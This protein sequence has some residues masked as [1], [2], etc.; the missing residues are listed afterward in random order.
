M[1]LLCYEYQHYKT[2][3]AEIVLDRPEALNAVDEKMSCRL[4]FVL[5]SWLNNPNI[6]E[7]I[8][9]S[10]GK[11]FCAGADLKTLMA[12]KEVKSGSGEDYFLRQY[13][14]ISMLRKSK[15]PIWVFAS[16]ATVGFGAGLFMAAS[17]RV[18][19]PSFYLAMPE[20][21]IGFFPDVGAIKFL[22]GFK[23]ASSVFFSGATLRIQDLIAAG[24]LNAVVPFEQFDSWLEARP[25]D[26][27]IDYTEPKVF[28]RSSSNLSIAYTKKMMLLTDLSYGEF[29]L[30]EYALAR[31]LVQTADFSQGIDAF[32]KKVLPKWQSKIEL[33][34]LNEMQEN[35]PDSLKNRFI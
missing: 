33:K 17:H 9:R 10:S 1:S 28:N 21:S 26:F 2:K 20:C 7:I 11:N 19:D 30:Y 16:G 31:E 29:A 34:D 5:E 23:K 6:S 35:I 13:H 12:Q 27:V 14:T 25:S 3:F 18:C 22:Q 24:L 32:F 8:I 4:H 15:K